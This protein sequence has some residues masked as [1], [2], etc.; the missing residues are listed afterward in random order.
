LLELKSVGLFIAH[1]LRDWLDKPP[2]KVSPDPLRQDFLTLA[3]SRALLAA[4]PDWANGCGA[5]CKCTPPGVMALA[6]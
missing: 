6:P 4:N 3:D 1:Q 2:Q 5:I